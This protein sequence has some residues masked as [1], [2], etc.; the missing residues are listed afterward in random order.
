M[1]ITIDR[2]FFTQL[3]LLFAVD[4]PLIRQPVRGLPPKAAPSADA[5]N[6]FGLPPSPKGEGFRFAVSLA[7]LFPKSDRSLLPTALT[8]RFASA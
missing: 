4:L 2:A 7:E 6:R 1:V 5:D 3:F 8:D